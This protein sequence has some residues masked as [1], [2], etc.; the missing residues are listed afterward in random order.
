MFLPF[1]ATKLTQSPWFLNRFP[2]SSVRDCQPPFLHW[3]PVIAAG[4][5][6]VMLVTA[7]LER[8]LLLAAYVAVAVHELPALMQSPE[9]AIVAAPAAAGF[10]EAVAVKALPVYTAEAEPNATVV[11]VGA[12]SIVMFALALLAACVVLPAKVAVAV[13]VLPGFVQSP[14][15][16]I[17]TGPAPTGLTDAVAVNALPVGVGSPSSAGTGVRR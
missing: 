12:L 14:E 10:T 2:R 15:Y 9:Y 16:E 11:D 6:I 13:H 3:S 7:L 1:V 17:V 5:L 4:Y 8:K